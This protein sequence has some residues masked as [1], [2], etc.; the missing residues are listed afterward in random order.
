MRASRT[1]TARTY[2]AQ[3]VPDDVSA[4]VV[5][6]SSTAGAVAVA[7]GLASRRRGRRG[8]RRGRRR[9]GAGDRDLDGRVGGGSLPADLLH[10]T[11]AVGGRVAGDGADEAALDAEL[12]GGGEHVRA[13]PIGRHDRAARG[14][15]GGVALPAE[16]ALR[17]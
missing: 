17:P 11:T 1:S 16:S 9:G 15:A 6:G 12:T 3:L 13:R 2:A 8:G 10:L 5:A 4:A 14:R 7:E